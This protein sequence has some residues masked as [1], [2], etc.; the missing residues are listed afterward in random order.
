MA[1]DA[2]PIRVAALLEQVLQGMVQLEERI[3]AL[4]EL[5]YEV[6]DEILDEEE[7]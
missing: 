2:G 3:A 1:E 6:L 5:T 4:E 7:E